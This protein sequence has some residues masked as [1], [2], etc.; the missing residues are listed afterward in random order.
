MEA[1]PSFF[2]RSPT[3]KFNKVEHKKEILE[4]LNTGTYR[5]LSLLPKV[6]PKTAVQIIT[7]RSMKKFKTIDD[8]QRVP[9]MKGKIWK[10][11][12]E[13]EKENVKLEESSLI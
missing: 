10:N 9:T 11:F 13:V 3:H 4:L 8:V 2:N 6:G 5:Q 1:I 7:C 12:L